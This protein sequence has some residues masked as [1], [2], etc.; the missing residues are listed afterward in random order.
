M[1]ED[2]TGALVR[3]KVPE[4]KIT[5]HQERCSSTN[6]IIIKEDTANAGVFLLFICLFVFKLL[7]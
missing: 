1:S 2:G 3:N 4:T 7:T 6:F 5:V